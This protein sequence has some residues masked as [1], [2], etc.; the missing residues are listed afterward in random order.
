MSQ[1]LVAYLLLA[2]LILKATGFIVRDELVLR[3]LVSLGIICDL[4]FY[5]L[6]PVPILQSVGS[7]GVL[8]SINLFLVILII[9]ERTKVRMTRD[10][11]RLYTHFSTLTPGQFRK[12]YGLVTW[13]RSTEQTKIIEEGAPLSRLYVILGERFEILKRGEIYDGRGPAFAGEIAFLTDQPSSAA[14]YVPD[15]TE[16]VSID[17]AALRKL[18]ARSPALNNSMIALFSRDLATKVLLSVPMDGI[19]L[20]PHRTGLAHHG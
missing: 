19:V 10:Q 1:E 18:M 20:E 2:G 11:R 7:N 14:V 17:M 13:H 16:Y 5:A 9:F 8:A 12:V 6:Q 15:D 3:L 4:L